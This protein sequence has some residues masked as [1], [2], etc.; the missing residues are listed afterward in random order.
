M[1]TYLRIS[2][3]AAMKVELNVYVDYYEIYKLYGQD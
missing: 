1:T 2:F 3:A